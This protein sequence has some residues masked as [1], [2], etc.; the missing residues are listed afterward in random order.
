MPF[1]GLRHPVPFVVAGLALALV[2]L[3]ATRRLLALRPETPLPVYGTVP[4]FDLTDE[5][6][7]LFPSSRLQGRPWIADFVFTGC[8]DSCPLLTARMA[9]LQRRLPHARLVTF[10]VDPD[11]DSPARLLDYAHKAGADPVRWS[12]LT[13]PVDRLRALV[14]HGFK[15]TMLRGDPSDR[16]EILHDNHLVL[17]DARGRIRGYYAADPHGANEIARDAAI[18][19]R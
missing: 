3:F 16:G 9:E 15:L 4:V 13:G 17:V 2:G 1:P 18:L 8:T 12:F 5:R 7:A 10:T 6:G 11:R 14:V 19:G